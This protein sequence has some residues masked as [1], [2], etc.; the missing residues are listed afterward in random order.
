MVMVLSASDIILQDPV[1]LLHLVLV[2][3]FLFRV[4][5]FPKTSLPKDSVQPFIVTELICQSRHLL[6]A[7]M[8][9]LLP[10]EIPSSPSTTELHPFVRPLENFFFF[11]FSLFQEGWGAGYYNLQTLLKVYGD[12][13]FHSIRK[14]FLCLSEWQMLH[15]NPQTNGI[16]YFCV[17]CWRGIELFPFAE[18][19]KCGRP[20]LLPAISF[21]DNF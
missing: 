12:S 9:A 15:C 13:K 20:N 16:P 1:H 8:R 19:Q 6:K 14:S 11:F 7:L 17:L 10:K 21:H 18:G 5:W 4:I 2:S 3:S